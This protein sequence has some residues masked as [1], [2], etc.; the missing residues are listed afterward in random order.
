VGQ[1]L[2]YDVALMTD[3]RFSGA[4]HGLM[5]GHVG[6]E[7]MDGGPIGLLKEGDLITFDVE[8]GVLNVDLP[9]G[10]MERRRAEW[11]PIA[12]RFTSGALAKYARQVG[13]ACRGAVTG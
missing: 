5:A 11:K 4:T 3:G 7:A 8:K 10:E 2:G 1:G 12:P 6:P 13:P 9:D